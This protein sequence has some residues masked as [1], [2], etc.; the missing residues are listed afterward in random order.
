MAQV[1]VRFEQD[2]RPLF[3]D[4]DVTSMASSFDLS[5]YDDVR[6]RA[7]QILSVVSAGRMPCDGAWPADRVALFRAWVDAGCPA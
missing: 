1:D 7:S 2:I 5:S 6:D 3:R 4:K